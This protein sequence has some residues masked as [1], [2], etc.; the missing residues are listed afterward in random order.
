MMSF[1]SALVLVAFTGF[2]ALSFEIL[3]SRLYSFLS[4]SRAPAFAGMLGFYL[5]GLALGSLWSI[6]FQKRHEAEGNDER[7]AAVARLVLWANAAAFLLAPVVSWLAMIVPY[8]WTYPLVMLV[9]GV[10]GT[11]LPLICH[12]SMPPDATVGSRLS[13]IYLANIVGSGAGSLLTGFVLM[14]YLSLRW[15]SLL[16]LAISAGIFIMLH[17]A[18]AFR[19][20]AR[21]T[22]LKV[23]A[24]GAI[25]TPLLHW[26]FWER[27]Q[28][29]PSWHWSP[30]SPFATVIESRSGVITVTAENLKA[31]PPQPAYIYGGGA[32]DGVIAVKP[33]LNDWLVRAYSLSALHANP[34]DVLMI[35][36]SGG[37]WAQIVAANPHVKRLTLI[38][39]NHSYRE[40]IAAH[41]CVRSLLTNSKVELIIDDGRRWLERNPD[42]K[43][44]AILMNTT[45]HWREFSGNLLSSDFLKI[46]YAHVK[47]HGI[48]QY[49]AT[50]SQRVART[51]LDVF[52][53]A[54]MV[55]N[56]VV[57]SPDELHFD[58]QR[59]EPILKSYQIDGQP[60]FDPASKADQAVLEKMLALAD[61]PGKEPAEIATLHP[62]LKAEPKYRLL[63]RA[64]MEAA[65]AGAKPITDDNLGHEYE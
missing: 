38:E 33:A 22:A 62:A 32:Y 64:Q 57:I 48:F 4:A 19:C 63:N 65:A 46:A 36:L 43:F 23:L 30:W 49:N 40:V 34:E 41:D 13:K 10:M 31:D 56:N 25:L 8:G 9:S 5:L 54:M 2:N 44:D 29:D 45:H 39:I 61:T 1:R 47:P 24:A 51:A 60:M 12:F 42:R 18:G 26:Q 59:W 55:L 20:R 58:R 6:R 17:P 50:D 52:P 7:N 3:W 35:G 16:L 28:K 14:E 27:I 15:I 21:R 11:L 37:S 53:H